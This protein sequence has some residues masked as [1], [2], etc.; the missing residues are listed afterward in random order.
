MF[1]GF[2]AA[3]ARGPGWP[4]WPPQPRLDRRAANEIDQ[5]I[6]RILAIAALG[7]MTLR[8]NDQ[9][10][11]ASEPRTGEPFEPRTHFGWQRRRRAD[12]EAQ[13]ELRSRAC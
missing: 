12:I 9:Y 1:F 3:F 4:G 8:G 10:A 2:H 5:P 7:A 13:A 6:E 11:V